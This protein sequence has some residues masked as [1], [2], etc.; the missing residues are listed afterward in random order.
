MRRLPGSVEAPAPPR[1]GVPPRRGVIR[2][3]LEP[4][5]VESAVRRVCSAIAG[6]AVL[7]LLA[8][9]GGEVPPATEQDPREPLTL[10]TLM[11]HMATTS[12]V[13]A[14]FHELKE[15]A[16]LDRPLESAGTLYVVP[17][18]RLAHYTTRPTRSVFVIDG[19]RLSF[20]DETGG[21]SV[22]LSADPIARTVVENFVVLFNGDLE[23]LQARYDV[24][25]EAQGPRWQL[26]LVPR[27]SRVIAVVSRVMLRGNGVALEQMVVSEAG[28][29]R[30]VTTFHDV[31]NEVRF[32]DAELARIF[33]HDPNAPP[34]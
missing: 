3:G 12:G 32:S 14:E 20:R 30:T 22:D 8:G 23:A 25:F 21:E 4:L 6:T 18:R 9:A 13:R 24:G 34:P 11:Q 16:L 28:G 33:S 2:I 19:S 1:G 27:D 5:L 29:D 7:M 10:E 26:D 31:R 15:I 17:P